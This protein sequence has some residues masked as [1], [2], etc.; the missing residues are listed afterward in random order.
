MTEVTDSETAALFGTGEFFQKGNY[1]PV[2][3]EL[4]DFDLPVQALG[5]IPQSQLAAVPP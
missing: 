4:T 2:E 1:A 5:A 3:S